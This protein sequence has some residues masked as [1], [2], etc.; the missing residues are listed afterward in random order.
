MTSSPSLQTG[1]SS[2]EQQKGSNSSLTVGASADFSNASGQGT[3]PGRQISFDDFKDFVCNATNFSLAQHGDRREREFCNDTELSVRLPSYEQYWRVAVVPATNRLFLESSIGLS[4][5]IADEVHLLCQF[6]Y[7]ILSSILR[8][9]HHMHGSQD[10]VYADFFG[11]LQTSCEQVELLMLARMVVFDNSLTWQQVMNR[12]R[13]LKNEVQR[14]ALLDTIDIANT[15]QWGTLHGLSREIALIRNALC[16]GPEIAIYTDSS[17]DFLA[18]AISMHARTLWT[19]LPEARDHNSLRRYFR[20]Q[21][22][23]ME[24]I[25]FRYLEKLNLVY[26]L[27]SAHDAARMTEQNA[28]SKYLSKQFLPHENMPSISRL[29]E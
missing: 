13:G 25:L 27:I 20:N 1:D 10:G 9:R 22:S 14:Q 26:K 12:T 16:H 18:P 3:Q 15:A 23:E 2:E 6:N 5:T 17:G 29:S 19:H 24:K 7:T 4:S 8:A 28:F 11:A 21:R